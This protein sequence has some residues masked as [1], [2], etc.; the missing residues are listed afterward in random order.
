MEQ[1]SAG[2]KRT[3]SDS[4]VCKNKNNQLTNKQKKILRLV[5]FELWLHSSPFTGYFGGN[6]SD[7][8]VSGIK[9]TGKEESLEQCLHDTVGDVFCPMPVHDPSIAGVT[10]VDSR[11]KHCTPLRYEHFLHYFAYDH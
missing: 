1:R 6:S 4:V 11:S 3:L 5:L 10:C 8:M 7:I 9:C 2:I